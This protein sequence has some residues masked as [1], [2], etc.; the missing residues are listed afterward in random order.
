MR[1]DRIFFGNINLAL[2]VM[3]HQSKKTPVKFRCIRKSVPLLKHNDYYENIDTREK[4][5]RLNDCNVGEVYV[6]EDRLI[7]FSGVIKKLD[8]LDGEETFIPKY[9]SRRKVLSLIKE[10]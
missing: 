4:Y 5:K 7:S 6:D 2:L 10:K 3:V 8:E 9:I 1:T